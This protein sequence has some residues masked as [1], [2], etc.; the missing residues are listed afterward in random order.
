MILVSDSETR[1]ITIRNES[2]HSDSRN[3]D[4]SGR[5]SNC[6]TGSRLISEEEMKS[7]KT[8]PRDLRDEQKD[9]PRVIPPRSV[10][11]LV[12]SDSNTPD[13][14]KDVG[15]EF[16][17]GYYSKQDGLDVIWLVNEDGKY[18]QTTDRQFL[19]KYF[20]PVEISDE[21]DLYG[22]A[23]PQLRRLRRASMSRQRAKVN[24]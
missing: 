17:V 6:D 8:S 20:E 2:H 16:R 24:V 4:F 3:L 22:S 9:L 14:K 10:F 23:K 1:G 15:R 5:L 11:R 7:R 18:E 12:R 21:S 13:W 19:L